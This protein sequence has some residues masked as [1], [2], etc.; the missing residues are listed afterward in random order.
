MDKKFHWTWKNLYFLS[1]ITFFLYFI[2]YE[3]IFFQIYIRFQK[4]S[5]L[6]KS[7][8]K[9]ATQKRTKFPEWP[10]Q[11]WD[12]SKNTQCV[13]KGHGK[14][15]IFK[16]KSRY[17]PCSLELSSPLEMKLQNVANRTEMR[18][19]IAVGHCSRNYILASAIIEIEL[20]A[21]VHSR[22]NIQRSK[23]IALLKNDATTSINSL[24]KSF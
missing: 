16:K 21:M 1:D 10:P 15:R 24:D 2:K 8:K 14:S 19:R 18:K 5:K 13:K 3:I 4:S 22:W 20:H 17:T 12:M 9:N 23:I 7:R 6:W 11:L